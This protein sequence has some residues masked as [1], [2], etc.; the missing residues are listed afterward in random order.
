[1]PKKI[2]CYIRLG[3]KNIKILLKQS[4]EYF[5]SDEYKEAFSKLVLVHIQ[6]E[7]YDIH[8][9]SIINEFTGLN[10]CEGKTKKKCIEEFENVKV[11]YETMLKNRKDFIE[12]EH[13]V[14]E[15]LR[16]C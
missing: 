6:S 15:N 4:G 11:P 12:N 16:S 10:V 13:R 14:L 3:R 1:M 8:K 5:L 7:E 9:W 2:D